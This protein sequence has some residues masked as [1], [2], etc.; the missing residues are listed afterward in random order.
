MS[1]SEKEDQKAKLAI[2]TDTGFNETIC[3]N[4]AEI[5]AETSEFSKNTELP[6]KRT[7]TTT[8][9]GLEFCFAVKEKLARAANKNF[10]VH[11]TAYHAFLVSSKDRNMID[12]KIKELV[13]LAKKLSSHYLLGLI[14][15]RT[16]LKLRLLRIYS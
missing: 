15:R 10:H 6:E 1:H 11:V 12:N 3:R 8:E 2:T 5:S 13:T 4:N 7:I 9:K 14:W 16:L